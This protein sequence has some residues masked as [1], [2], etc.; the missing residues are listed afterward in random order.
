MLTSDGSGGSGGS[1]KI[2]LSL[3]VEEKVEE[4]TDAMMSNSGNNKNKNREEDEEV[5]EEVEEVEEN[6]T[7][8]RMLVRIEKCIFHNISSDVGTLRVIRRPWQCS[9]PSTRGTSVLW[10]EECDGDI[11]NAS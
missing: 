3:K 4:K 5:D 10:V 6:V 11:T 7:E 1:Q 2:E 9:H 8:A